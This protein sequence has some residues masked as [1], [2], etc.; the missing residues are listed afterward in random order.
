MVQR[1][2]LKDIVKKTRTEKKTN[3]NTL[4]L[5]TDTAIKTQKQ[6]HRYIDKGITETDKET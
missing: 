2:R 4:I 6:K 1:H 3:I 5:C